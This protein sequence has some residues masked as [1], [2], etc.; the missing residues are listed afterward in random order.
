MPRH[1]S[2]NGESPATDGDSEVAGVNAGGVP[3]EPMRT[4]PPNARWSGGDEWVHFKWGG[5][6]LLVEVLR[7]AAVR[8]RSHS[9][10]SLNRSGASILDAFCDP[11]LAP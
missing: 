1:Q 3:P 7:S 2:P 9:G 6:R 11:P 8:A 5:L 4:T 10:A